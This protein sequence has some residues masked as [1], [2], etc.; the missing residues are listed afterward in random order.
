MVRYLISDKFYG[1][2]FIIMLKVTAHTAYVLKEK[3]KHN[4][5]IK[6]IQSGTKILNERQRSITSSERHS[7]KSTSSKLIM[8]LDAEKI[9]LF[10]IKLI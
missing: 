2:I 1:I 6:S 8:S 3:N 4:E 5:S 7:L 10:L 9:V